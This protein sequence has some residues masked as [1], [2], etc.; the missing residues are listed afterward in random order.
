MK[1]VSLK[2]I[3][4]L[5]VALCSFTY[6]NNP[7]HID[8]CCE[9]SS[10]LNADDSRVYICGGKYATKFHSYSRCRGLNNCR[11][12]IYYYESEKDAKNAGYDYCNICWR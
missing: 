2:V 8:S 11:G 5:F 12:G 3:V 7:S 4:I 10:C 1:N 6:S 9:N